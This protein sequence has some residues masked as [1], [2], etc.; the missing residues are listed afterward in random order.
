MKYWLILGVMVIGL[1][2]CG[3]KSGAAIPAPQTRTVD[4][5][6]ISLTSQAKAEINTAQQWIVTIVDTN[7]QPVTG[8]DVFLDLVMSGM[9]M[10][11]NKPLATD[12]GDGT[13]T[14][15]G[16]YSMGGEWQVAVHASIDDTDHIA[17]FEI[18]V[19]E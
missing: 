16:L 6:A 14:A 13:Y 11:Q 4:G 9:T 1:V 15:D 12:N 2:G 10:G 8:A 17:V 3:S 18:T 5:F 19:P 7:G